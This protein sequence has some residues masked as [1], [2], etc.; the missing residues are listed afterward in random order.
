V[1][2]ALPIADI[3]PHVENTQQHVT[4]NSEFQT[5]TVVSEILNQVD[6]CLSKYL[7][8][9][10]DPKDFATVSQVILVYSTVMATWKFTNRLH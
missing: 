5:V 2:S 10:A 7:E 6:Y 4:E 9:S 1:Y 8:C 3:V